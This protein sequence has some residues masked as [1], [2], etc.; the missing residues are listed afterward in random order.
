[1]VNI[2]YTLSGKVKDGSGNPLGQVSI[3]IGGKFR[4]VTDYQ[5]NYTLS[6]LIPGAYVISAMK[7]GYTMQPSS[8]L[9]NIPLNITNLS[10]VGVG[11]V[12]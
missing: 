8:H 2:T 7:D 1:M 4:A 3:L 9:V 10:F 6:G 12:R 11:S 5:G